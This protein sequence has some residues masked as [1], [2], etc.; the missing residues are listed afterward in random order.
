MLTERL[1]V[2]PEAALGAVAEADDRYAPVPRPVAY[3]RLIDAEVGS[4]P[5]GI[6]KGWQ[7]A[8]PLGDQ[9]RHPVDHARDEGVDQAVG[10][11]IEATWEIAAHPA[12]SICVMKR[13]AS[14]RKVV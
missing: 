3:S 2:E 4:S 5:S 6:E 12:S 10:N 13:R 8:E 14:S 1:R 9:L 11:L 7:I